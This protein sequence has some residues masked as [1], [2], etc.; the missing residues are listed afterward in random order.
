MLT[1]L[2][3]IVSNSGVDFGVD[4]G[5]DFEIDF[6]LNFGFVLHF[7]EFRFYEYFVEKKKIRALHAQIGMV[8]FELID[9]KYRFFDFVFYLTIQ[10]VDHGV[11]PQAVLLFLEGKGLVEVE[12]WCKTVNLLLS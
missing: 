1:D 12:D 6:E 4:F 8:L 9:Q 11:L 2:S 5:I 10:K 7:L 3:K